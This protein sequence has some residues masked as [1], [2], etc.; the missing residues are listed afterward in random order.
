LIICLGLQARADSILNGLSV[1]LTWD[2]FTTS[3]VYQPYTNAV[4]GSGVEFLAGAVGTGVGGSETGGCGDDPPYCYNTAISVDL[5]DNVDTI[6]LFGEDNGVN[7]N[8]FNPDEPGETFNGYDIK[9]LSSFAGF[10]SV[11]IDTN[12][13]V[14][15]GFT[16]SDLSFT[17]TDIYVNLIGL[18][19]GVGNQLTLEYTVNGSQST[20]PEPAS[21]LLLGTGLV[22]VARRFR[23]RSA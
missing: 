10:A 21:L 16:S 17:S 6:T 18:P 11:S 13:S 20:T 12:D 7:G 22:G 2:A 4:V 23:K 19:S 9:V 5:S 1:G 15:S 8:F 14:W 3:S